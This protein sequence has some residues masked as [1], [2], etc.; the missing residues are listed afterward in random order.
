M[1]CNQV[2]GIYAEWITNCTD[3][4]EDGQVVLH[5]QGDGR[6][7]LKARAFQKR[8]IVLFKDL[9]ALHAVARDSRPWPTKSTEYNLSSG[10]SAL[11]YVRGGGKQSP[12]PNGERSA[13]NVRRRRLKAIVGYSMTRE[14]W[15]VEIQ[16]VDSAEAIGPNG[17]AET[18]IQWKP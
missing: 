4:I 7:F 6:E 14:D 1:Y 10:D 16:D 2:F 15:Q 13:I 17:Q 9:S 8:E 12:V 18:D 11:D 3:F 5:F